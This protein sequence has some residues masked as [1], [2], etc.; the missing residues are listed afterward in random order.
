MQL[1]RRTKASCWYVN[2]GDWGSGSRIAPQRNE[3]HSVGIILHHVSH[4]FG[5]VGKYI[6]PLKEME[7]GFGIL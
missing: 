6:V 2:D 5:G 3:S 4:F 7:Y 1:P